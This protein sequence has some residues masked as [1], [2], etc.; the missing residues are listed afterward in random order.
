MLGKVIDWM[1][2][3]FMGLIS[4]T[5][6]TL[7]FPV[8]LRASKSRKADT[9]DIPVPLQA[10]P[11]CHTRICHGARKSL[12]VGIVQTPY[13]IL[14]DGCSQGSRRHSQYPPRWR[15]RLCD[16]LVASRP[17][18]AD[19]WRHS[20]CPGAPPQAAHSGQSNASWLVSCYYCTRRRR[21]RLL[22]LE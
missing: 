4:H 16:L 13:H 12:L 3:F 18:S 15:P 9:S 14:Q 5:K 17:A 6:S 10:L 22:Q 8:F 11:K 21:Q 1:Y 2:F 7:C 20:R 19:L